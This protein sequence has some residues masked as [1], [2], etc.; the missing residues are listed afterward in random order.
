MPATASP[1]HRPDQDILNDLT[2]LLVQAYEDGRVGIKPPPRHEYDPDVYLPPDLERAVTGRM[3]EALQAG[4][5][6]G[7]IMLHSRVPWKH[8][9]RWIDHAGTFD[10]RA[11]AYR[12]HVHYLDQ[13]LGAARRLQGQ[14][15]LELVD[16]PPGPHARP[17]LTKQD[18]AEKLGISRPTLDKWLSWAKQVPF[19]DHACTS[20]QP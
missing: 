7:Q 6:A 17:K 12:A 11:A 4:L 18:A 15:A 14:L 8:V 10:D 5:T 1:R 2:P 9:L 3:R 19:G 16:P 20:Q 13:E